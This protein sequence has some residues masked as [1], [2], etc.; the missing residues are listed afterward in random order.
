M[1]RPRNRLAIAAAALMGVTSIAHLIGGEIDVHRPLLLDVSSAE[2]SLYVSVLWHG[3][4]AMLVLNTAALVYGARRGAGASPVMLLA[5]AQTLALALIFILYGFLRVG[6]PF[7][8]PQWTILLVAGGLACLAA[9][10][11][12]TEPGRMVP[13]DRGEARLGLDDQV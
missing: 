5:G 2:R 10:P 12:R 9:R 1:N 11:A 4:S 3:V 13:P 6:G 7:T 8:A